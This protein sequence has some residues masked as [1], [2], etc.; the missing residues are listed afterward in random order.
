MNDPIIPLKFHASLQE[1]EAYLKEEKEKL[2]LQ[3]SELQQ[4]QI[5]LQYRLGIV[6]N[7]VQ[8]FANLKLIKPESK[9]SKPTFQ[10]IAACGKEV[11]FITYDPCECK[12]ILTSRLHTNSLSMNVNDL[13]SV[14]SF[15]TVNGA[16]SVIYDFVRNEDLQSIRHFLLSSKVIIYHKGVETIFTCDPES[17]SSQAGHM[18]TERGFLGAVVAA[19]LAALKQ[20]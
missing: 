2:K 5:D 9:K 11:L 7:A 16:Q 19:Y 15:T 18:L 3:L 12:Y 13:R 4:Q 20:Q 14:G 17:Q 1:A 8:S 10:W 6:S